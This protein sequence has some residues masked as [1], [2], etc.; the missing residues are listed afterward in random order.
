MFSRTNTDSHFLEVHRDSGLV[1]SLF[2]LGLS[3]RCPA[4]WT[5]D[6]PG[7]HPVSC[8]LPWVPAVLPCSLHTIGGQCKQ[9]RPQHGACPSQARVPWDRPSQ[10]P[11]KPPGKRVHSSGVTQSWVQGQPLLTFCVTWNHSVNFANS[12]LLIRIGIVPISMHCCKGKVKSHTAET[13]PGVWHTVCGK[14]Y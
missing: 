2:L 3:C 14:L 10:C 7:E 5:L 1:Y 8:A 9:C 11:E 12:R 4:L 6:T 13:W